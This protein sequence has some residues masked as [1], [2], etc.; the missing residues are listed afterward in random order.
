MYILLPTFHWLELSLSLH[1]PERSQEMSLIL[2]PREGEL[3][4][5]ISAYKVWETALMFGIL[6]IQ[7]CS[8]KARR[9]G[10]HHVT[11]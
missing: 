6:H 9:G 2:C 3:E 11:V 1:L 10:N 8:F 7:L 5:G 4:V